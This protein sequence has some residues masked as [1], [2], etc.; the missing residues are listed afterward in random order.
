MPSLP[1]RFTRFDIHC[2][3]SDGAFPPRWKDR[4]HFL[5]SAC[6]SICVRW[7]VHVVHQKRK[8]LMVSSACPQAH[9]SDSAAPI[10]CRYPFSRAIP[11][12][13]CASMLASFRLRVLYR[14]WVCLSGSAVSISVEYLPTPSE[15]AFCSC[16][17][18]LAM[19]IVVDL[20]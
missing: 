8:C 19:F 10:R 7:V 9:W 4:L 20:A 6:R 14:M 12:R 16:C 18:A 13:S 17:F 5:V 3:G 11:I 2:S 1:L 15:R